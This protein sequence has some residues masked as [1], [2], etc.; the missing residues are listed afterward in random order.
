MKIKTEQDLSCNEVEVIIKYPQKNKQVNRIMDFLQSFDMQIKCDSGDTERMVN[1]LD[2]YY[3]ESVDKKTFV[4]LENAVYHTAFRLY[5]LKDKLQTYG[6]VQI[7]KSCILN[8][9][10][11]ESIRPLFNSRMEATLKNGEKVNINRNYLNGV[12]KALKGEEI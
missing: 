2:I 4:Y 1:I 8:I 10:A 9:N 11:L 3:I 12:K 7:S 6:F 5:Q